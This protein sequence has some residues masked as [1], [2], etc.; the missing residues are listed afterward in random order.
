M[1]ESCRVGVLGASS[2]VGQCLLPR[3][4]QEGWRVSAYSRKPGDDSAGG[5]STGVEWRQLLAQ[6]S[7]EPTPYWISLAPIWLLSDYFPLLE[8]SGVRRLVVLSSTSRFTKLNSD[9]VAEMAV[10]AN[11]IDAEERLASWAKS[12]GISWVVLRPTLIYGLGRDKNV[13]EIAHFIRK[14]RFFPILGEANGL[15]QPVHVDDVA[16]A[17]AAALHLPVSANRAYNL[18]GAERLPYRELVRRI[19]ITLGQKPYVATVPLWVFRLAVMLLRCLPRY[20]HWSVAMVERM[21]SDLVFDHT[22][23]QRDLGFQ[24]RPFQPRSEDLVP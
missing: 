12:R 22:D 1:A 10:A 8:A 11:L 24:P 14:F 15:R 9:D 7:A 18:S 3:L 20:R 19:F 13:A 2:L 23:A 5:D 6:I 17:C 21:S 4:V 16:S